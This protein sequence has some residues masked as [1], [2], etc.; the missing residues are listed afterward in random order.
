MMIKIVLQRL[1]IELTEGKEYT[2]TKWMK[3]D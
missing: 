1:L 3:K 2:T